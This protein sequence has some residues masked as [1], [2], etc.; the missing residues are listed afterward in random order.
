V[1]DAPYSTLLRGRRQELHARVAAALG[2]VMGE[3]FGLAL[4]EIGEVLLHRRQYRARG[5]AMAEGRPACRGA[6]GLPR[7][8]CSSPA[9]S[10][11]AGFATESPSRNGREIELQLAL[12]LC[13]FTGKGAVESMQPYARARE[14]AEKGG[15]PQQRRG[16]PG[17]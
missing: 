16:S 1:Q 8:D 10:Q 3:Q 17:G 5:R 7:S 13:L 14:L 12:G 15:A 4:D 11:R 6:I 2:Q 9:R